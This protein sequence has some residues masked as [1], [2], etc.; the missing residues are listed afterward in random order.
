M[1][2]PIE[3]VL[4]LVAE[5]RL[6]AEEAA[7]V[8]DAL[9]AAGGEADDDAPGQAEFAES[10]DEPAGRQPH[11]LRIQVTGGGRSIVNL[12]VPL[13]FGRMALDRVPGLS[14]DTVRRIRD[15]LDHGLT[16]PLV[17]VDD[18]DESVRITL[19]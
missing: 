18:D 17:A 9:G 2:D 19:E 14:D 4:R 8:L 16:G 15:A 6:T 13:A 7:P 5:G 10:A 12:R 3:E 11:A 1:P